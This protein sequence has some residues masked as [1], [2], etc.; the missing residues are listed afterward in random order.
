MR[1]ASGLG[2]AAAIM[3]LVAVTGEHHKALWQ[4]GALSANSS[5][6]PGPREPPGP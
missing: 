1:I 6:H 5:T 4:S 3:L 2:A